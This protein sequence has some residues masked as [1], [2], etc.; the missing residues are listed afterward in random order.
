MF[1]LTH[2]KFAIRP[3]IRHNSDWNRDSVIKLVAKAVGP[4]HQVDL[5]NYDLLILVDIMRVSDLVDF[6]S[7]TT[8]LV[9]TCFNKRTFVG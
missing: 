6:L 7:P 5:K 1:R 8:D 3:T 9:L 2:L 4:G